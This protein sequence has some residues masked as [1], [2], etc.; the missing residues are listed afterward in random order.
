MGQGVP[1]AG[2]CAGSVSE[3]RTGPGW[4]RPTVG[5]VVQPVGGLSRVAM[6]LGPSTG[7]RGAGERWTCTAGVRGRQ[8]PADARERVDQSVVVSAQRPGE[9]YGTPRVTDGAAGVPTILSIRSGERARTGW[10]RV[11]SVLS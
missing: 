4:V 8:V 6:E 2:R 3:W 5:P 1:G 7:G 11:L 9:H 10:S